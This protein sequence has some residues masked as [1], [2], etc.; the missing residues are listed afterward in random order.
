MARPARSRE[1]LRGRRGGAG[2]VARA[3]GIGRS[4]AQSGGGGGRAGSSRG[5]SSSQ[6]AIPTASDVTYE[7][8]AAYVV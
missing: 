7:A 1:I 5:G 3:G 2:G 6:L 4:V 8:E